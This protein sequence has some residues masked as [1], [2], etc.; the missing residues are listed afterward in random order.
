MTGI[1]RHKLGKI[2]VN[3]RG[4]HGDELVRIA[5]GLEVPVETL[6]DEGPRIRYR[7]NETKPTNRMAIDWFERCVDNSLFVRALLALHER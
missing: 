6:L 3:V 2:E 7:I 5:R 4:L 1:E